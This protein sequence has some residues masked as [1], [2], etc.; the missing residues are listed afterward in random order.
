M[1]FKVGDIVRNKD[2]IN[3]TYKDK[4]VSVSE[5]EYIIDCI[6]LNPL[7]RQKH[8]TEFYDKNHELDEYYMK[9]LEWNR[10]LKELLE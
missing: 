2:I 6:T 5:Q 4:I 8:Q 3:F 1:K 9:Q 10:Q 7:D